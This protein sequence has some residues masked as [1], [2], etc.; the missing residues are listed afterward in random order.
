MTDLNL[1]R[2]W[3]MLLAEPMAIGN[4][5]PTMEMPLGAW[6]DQ[7][8]VEGWRHALN[9]DWEIN[10]RDSLYET[11]DWLRDRGHHERYMA[12]YHNLMHFSEDGFRQLYPDAADQIRET[13]VMRNRNALK[14]VGVKA[15]DL[16]RLVMIVRQGCYTGLISEQEGW[17]YLFELGPRIQAEFTGWQQYALSYVV[18]RHLWR[19]APVSES[20]CNNLFKPL[21]PVLA[22]PDSGWNTVR[23]HTPLV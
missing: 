4:N 7:K 2:Q 22:N 8:S 23:W 12:V 11:L 21:F 20:N 3:L 15:W 17:D 1:A 13:L 18:G 5:A 10:S 9:R 14:S 19:D 16:V 6:D